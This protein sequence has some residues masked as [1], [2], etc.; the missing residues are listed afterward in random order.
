M[1]SADM[2]AKNTKHGFEISAQQ[3]QNPAQFCVTNTKKTE[4]DSSTWQSVL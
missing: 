1:N 4:A 2:T 3:A